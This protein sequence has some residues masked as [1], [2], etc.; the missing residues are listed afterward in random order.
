MK[1]IVILFLMIVFCGL[2]NTKNVKSANTTNSSTIQGLFSQSKYYNYTVK[3]HETLYSIS[4]RYG[5]KVKLLQEINKLNKNDVLA[6]G[7]ILKIPINKESIKTISNNSYQKPIN[8]YSDYHKKSIVINTAIENYGKLNVALMLPLMSTDTDEISNESKQFLQ[9]YEGFLV[10]LDSLRN[11]GI[12]IKLRVF[13]T[14]NKIN[15]V[16]AIMNEINNENYDLIVGPVYMENCEYVLKHL[17]NYN[18]PVI[19]PLSHMSG[20][21]YSYP[22]FIQIHMSNEAFVREGIK[23]VE[24]QNSKG[25]NIIY[26]RP[27]VVENSIQLNI[28]KAISEI[29]GSYS[30]NDYNYE[31]FVE[32]FEL[33]LIDSVEN[34]IVFPATTEQ[35]MGKF[36]PL[37]TLVAESYKITI[38]GL[39]Q[40]Q[41][42]TSIDMDNLYKLNTKILSYSY[43]DPNINEAAEFAGKFRMSY[44]EE[45]T[46]LAYKAYDTALYFVNMS[47]RFGNRTLDMLWHNDEIMNFSLFKFRKVAKDSGYEN[48]GLYI[49]NYGSDYRI[50]VSMFNM[51]Y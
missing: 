5:V 43:V 7:T 33:H 23:W 24:R 37:L 22:N 31:T 25:S 27:S 14:E 4:K 42:F 36:L 13:D 50:K 9:F 47:N 1:K 41:L 10:G 38:V 17:I 16:E 39:P 40:W 26:L 49:I 28:K 21:M 8:E 46:S 3:A 44:G 35:E 12:K 32:N 34:L 15:K 30:F 20:D 6:V 2:V 11:K 19:Y 48:R 18:V 45:P 51:Q 29:P